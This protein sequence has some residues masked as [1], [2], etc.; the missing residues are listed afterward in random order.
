MMIAKRY[1]KCFLVVP[2][3]LFIL[4]VINAASKIDS[5]GRIN[6]NWEITNISTYTT[7][8][9]HLKKGN[10]ILRNN[11][12]IKSRD[13][14]DFRII[15][16]TYNRHNSL[17]RLLNSLNRAHYGRDKIVLDV[18]IDRSKLN[19]VHNDTVHTALQYQFNKGTCNVYIH[20]NH[21]G[22]TGQWLS[23]SKH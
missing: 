16:I 15:V 12:D 18:W 20:R 17:L 6:P 13:T 3:S 2:V 5:V 4:Y 14:V 19:L 11:T 7:R 10:C 22:I 21:V 23:V 9:L 1:L 8:S